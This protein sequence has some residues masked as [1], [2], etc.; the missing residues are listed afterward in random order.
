MSEVLHYLD[1]VKAALVPTQSR[2]FKD[3][4]P[5]NMTGLT[6][7]IHVHSKEIYPL[8]SHSGS[9][10]WGC[11]PRGSRGDRREGYRPPLR[12]ARQGFQKELVHLQR[13]TPHASVGD[14]KYLEL[15]FGGVGDM[16]TDPGQ[17][18]LLTLGM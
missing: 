9:R 11:I 1:Q 18:R 7:H 15:E 3:T 13:R 12:L 2:A 6:L 17:P 8:Y 16:S 14:S 10:T 5:C 4:T